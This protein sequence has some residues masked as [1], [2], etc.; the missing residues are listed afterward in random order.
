MKYAKVAIPI[1][2]IE[3]ARRVLTYSGYRSVNEF[4]IDSV[5]RRLEEL[6][7]AREVVE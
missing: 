2:L 7:R 6:E 1:E 4:V 3:R 5:R